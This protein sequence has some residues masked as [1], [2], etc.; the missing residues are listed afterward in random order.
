MGY[1]IVGIFPQTSSMVPNSGPK[2]SRSY[3][4][5]ARDPWTRMS[6]ISHSMQNPE[7][8][9]SQRMCVSVLFHCVP[10]TSKCQSLKQNAFST[11]TLCVDW[12]FHCSA[13]RQLECRMAAVVWGLEWAGAS[14]G[15]H[16][17]DCL[18]MGL[19]QELSSGYQRKHPHVDST[20]RLSFLQ[21]GGWAAKGS[22]PR[23]G[24]RQRTGWKQQGF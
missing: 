1:V 23:K 24:A 21:F 19:D 8:I 10:T 20:C 12:W 11:I 15:V 18:L 7:S 17:Q 16:L 13:W 14:Q 9:S 2:T 6:T 4:V 5:D 3:R 22:N